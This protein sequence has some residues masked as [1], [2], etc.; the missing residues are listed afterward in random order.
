MVN[1]IRKIRNVT[2]RIPMWAYSLLT[3]ISSLAAIIPPILAAI[4][5]VV[6]LIQGENAGI[7]WPLIGVSWLGVIILLLLKFIKDRM[8]TA[9]RIESVSGGMHQLTH[10]FRNTF[11]E[12]RHAYMRDTLT[13]DSLKTKVNSCLRDG[14]DALCDIMG[15]HWRESKRLYQTDRVQQC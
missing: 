1:L 9:K 11:F 14:L 15:L 3:L 4:S 12:I 5:Q 6:K 2:D 13:V 8:L 10:H 7:Q